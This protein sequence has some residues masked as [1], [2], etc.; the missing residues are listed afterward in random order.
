MPQAIVSWEGG[1]ASVVSRGPISRDEA[2]VSWGCPTEAPW[3][4]VSGV[5]T[6]R[7]VFSGRAFIKVQGFRLTQMAG[8]VLPTP[9]T[10]RG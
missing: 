5:K 4:R 6:P 2:A 3:S 8:E 9:G 10:S 1:E 7:G